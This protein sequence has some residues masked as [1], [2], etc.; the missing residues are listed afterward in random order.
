VRG[1]AD[2]LLNQPV[3]AQEGYDEAAFATMGLA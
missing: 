2:Q 1:R 3:F